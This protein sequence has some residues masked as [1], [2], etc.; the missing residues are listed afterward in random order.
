MNILKIKNNRNPFNTICP[1]QTK[2]NPIQVQ[3][4]THM[5]IK[6]T[7]KYLMKILINYNKICRKI[8]K[9]IMNL[10]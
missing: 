7:R 10:K 3:Y 2:Y 1:C 8:N 4:F 9:L 6:I 5:D